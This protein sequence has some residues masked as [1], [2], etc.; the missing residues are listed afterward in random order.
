M[1]LHRIFCFCLLLCPFLTGGCAGPLQR[2]DYETRYKVTDV[3]LP[4]EGVSPAQ[5]QRGLL[6][7]KVSLFEQEF[8]KPMSG[9]LLYSSHPRTRTGILIK[10]VSPEFPAQQIGLRVGDIILQLNDRTTGEVS[11]LIKALCLM[12]SAAKYV[13]HLIVWRPLSTGRLMSKKGKRDTREGIYIDFYF[14]FI[15]D[16]NA[17][18]MDFFPGLPFL[19]KYRRSRNFWSM[20]ALGG[21][22]SSYEGRHFDFFTFIPYLFD[23]ESFRAYSKS[24]F[25]FFSWEN[26][27]LSEINL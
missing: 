12:D 2:A 27:T 10:Q 23:V 22:I 3:R 7:I 13:N 15:N 14:S 21:L 5:D 11:D 1:L 26:G 20:E 17:G 24:Y 19:F 16:Y 25:L 4:S 8:P 9:D 6:G 18:G